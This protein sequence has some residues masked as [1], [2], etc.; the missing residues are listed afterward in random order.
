[1]TFIQCFMG[2]FSKYRD[3]FATFFSIILEPGLASNFALDRGL[4]ES[5]WI[6]VKLQ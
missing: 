1:M 5:A 2:I 4:Y 3:F 6:A